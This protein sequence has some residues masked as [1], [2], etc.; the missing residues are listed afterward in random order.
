MPPSDNAAVRDLAN[1]ATI[2]IDLV[3]ERMTKT[4]D[5][6]RL[7]E[8][9]DARSDGASGTWSKIQPWVSTVVAISALAKALG[10]I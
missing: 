9:H 10:W 1:A 5:R 7:L 2:R 6:V 3:E 8:L 4:E